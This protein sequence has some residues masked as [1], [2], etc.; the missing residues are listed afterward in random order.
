M[1]FCY[2]LKCNDGTYYCGITENIKRRIKQHNVD[3]G[4]KYLRGN[5]LPVKLVYYEKFRSRTNAHRRELEIKK[6]PPK[7][8]LELEENFRESL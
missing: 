7:K 5:K 6:L 1:I 8:K 3:K 2:L 4:R